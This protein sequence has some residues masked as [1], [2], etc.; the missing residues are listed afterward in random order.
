MKKLRHAL[1]IV[2][3]SDHLTKY[4]PDIDYFNLAAL[5]LVLPLG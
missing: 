5:G 4:S 3:P 1:S 2:T